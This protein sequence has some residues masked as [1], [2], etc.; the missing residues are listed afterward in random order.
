MSPLLQEW[1]RLARE[2]SGAS[3]ARADKFFVVEDSDPRVPH[4]R[5]VAS[6]GVSDARPHKRGVMLVCLTSDGFYQELG[7]SSRAQA[8]VVVSAL[9]DAWPD[10][11]DACHPGSSS[12]APSP[13]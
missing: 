3:T 12:G 11:L 9:R 1:Y 2:T 13:S 5:R 8:E 6:G 7:V 10:L 4:G